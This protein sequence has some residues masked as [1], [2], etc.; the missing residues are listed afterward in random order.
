MGWSVQVVAA[1]A[2]ETVCVATLLVCPA[3]VASRF[4]RQFLF[5]VEGSQHCRPLRTSPCSNAPVWHAQSCKGL[6]MHQ[7]SGVCQALPY[8]V[9]VGHGSLSVT[10]T[11]STVLFTQ[12]L[13]PQSSL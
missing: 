7:S 13:S 9:H 1:A 3:D 2:A 4:S 10:I 11:D 6:S 12:P 5:R 8:S